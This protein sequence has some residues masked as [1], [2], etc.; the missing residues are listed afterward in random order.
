MLFRSNRFLEFIE[1]ILPQLPED[2]EVTILDFGCGK[3]YLTFAMYHYLKELKGY[4]VHIIGLDLKEDVIAHCR[5]LAIK[6][7][8][9]GL[10]FYVGDIASYE[11][12]S[13]VDMVVTLHA[14]DTATD[15]ALD[16]AIRW[17]A[18]VILSVPCCQHEMNGQIKNEILAP[19]FSYGLIKERMAALFTDAIRAQIL[20][21][22]G[23]QVQILEFIDMEH[24]PKNIL[25][26][27]VKKGR[28]KSGGDYRRIMEFLH[29]QPTLAAL[30]DRGKDD[31]QNA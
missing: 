15:Y 11:G 18:K 8:Y 3:S 10:D 13:Q 9:A 14:C 7:G 2:R 28:A 12:I 26:R 6:Y 17:N 31:K 25:I 22:K 20:E 4:Q 29:V 19:I 30:Q 16:K 21:S 24:T 5:E 1:D 23:Y 27:A